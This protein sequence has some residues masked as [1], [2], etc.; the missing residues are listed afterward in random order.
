MRAWRSFIFFIILASQSC[1]GPVAASE[2]TGVE[3]TKRNCIVV[4]PHGPQDGGDFGP[5]TPGTKTSGLQEAFNAAKAQAKDIYLSGGSWTESKTVPVVYVLRETLHIPWMQNFRC[6]SGN[7]VIHYAPHEGDAVV[8]DSQMSCTY[9]FGL[10][11]SMSPGATVRLK[12]TT[13]GPDRFKVITST[14]FY[15]NAL[16]GGGGAWPSGE[17]FNSTLD[18]KRKWVGTGLLLDGSEG[19]IDANRIYVTEIVGCERGIH[20]T[21]DCTHNTIE[22]TSIHLS[23]THMQI[24]DEDVTPVRARLNRIAV[25]MEAQGIEN[26]A[27]AVIHGAENVINLSSEGM[28]KDREI[29]FGKHAEHN[30]VTV[31]RLKGFTNQAASPTNRI[32]TASPPAEM[33]TTPAVPAAG[34]EIANRHPWPILARII[35]PG[36]VERWTETPV[37]GAAQTFGGALASGQAIWLNPGDRLTIDY[38]EAPTWHWKAVQ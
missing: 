23:Q 36:K 24:G 13:A 26:A 28:A 19:P 20:L 22:A 9:R 11:V 10:I 27:G 35:R 30:L 3:R 6:D 37:V 2:P 14:D 29:V 7:C 1:P 32:V 25:H 33:T 12:P 21:H 18:K 34:V 5:H 16:V 17:A 4:T 38:T 8:I 31:A 15:F